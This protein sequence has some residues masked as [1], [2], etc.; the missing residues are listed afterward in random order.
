M[1][2]EPLASTAPAV[3]D[4][5]RADAGEPAVSGPSTSTIGR[6]P[7]RWVPVAGLVAYLACRLATVAAVAIAD[8]TTHNSVVFDLTRWDGA[9]FLRA[10]QS[11]Y[12]SHLPMTHGHVA[13]NPIAFFPL[14]PLVVRAG[15]AAGLDPGVAA[16]VLSGVTGLTA[17]QLLKMLV[18]DCNVQAEKVAGHETIC[19]RLL[20]VMVSAGMNGCCE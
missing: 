4:V 19:I 16:L 7:V 13:A 17:V 2:P 6:R 3:E 1:P 10:V 15:V 11:G 14:F 18:A 5:D 20:A 12:P 8:L 9:W